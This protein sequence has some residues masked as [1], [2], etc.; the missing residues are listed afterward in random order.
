MMTFY[1][2][3]ILA[4]GAITKS[5]QCD[6]TLV[7]L[8]AASGEASVAVGQMVSDLNDWVNGG[9][10]EQRPALADVPATKAVGVGQDWPVT[11]IPAGTVVR[12]DGAVVGTV[13]ATG[14]ILAFPVAALWHLRLEPPFPWK[15]ADCEV[16]V[17]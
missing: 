13:D 4:T 11:G 14:L 12:V 8:Q 2:S 16:T 6:T 10:V 5:G 9:V 1:A 3:Y 7:S 15:P 17:T